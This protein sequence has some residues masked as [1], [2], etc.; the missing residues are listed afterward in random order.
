MIAIV[1]Q[2]VLFLLIICLIF[3]TNIVSKHALVCAYLTSAD[4]K[5]LSFI[6]IIM[7]IFFFLLNFV[8]LKLIFMLLWN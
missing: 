2:I 5:S 4:C 6:L 8:W 7:S 3:A 1:A